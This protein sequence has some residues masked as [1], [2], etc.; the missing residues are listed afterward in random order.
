MRLLKK[1]LCDHKSTTNIEKTKQNKKQ[2]KTKTLKT[3]KDK[4]Y[5]IK[6]DFLQPI[7]ST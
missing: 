1:R 6:A 7:P 5:L 3:K 2:T 4:G